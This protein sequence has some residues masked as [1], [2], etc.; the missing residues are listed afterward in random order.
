MGSLKTGYDDNPQPY[1]DVPSDSALYAQALKDARARMVEYHE[2]VRYQYCQDVLS[3]D[4][5]DP[6]VPVV[7]PE[8]T[9]HPESIRVSNLRGP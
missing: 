4:I 9:Y 5:Y 8:Y 7:H 3:P 2:G 6:F 1:V